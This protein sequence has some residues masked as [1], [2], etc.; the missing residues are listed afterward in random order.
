M[1]ATQ[2]RY[3]AG[4]SA[5]THR[6]KGK[7]HQ[8]N[9]HIRVGLSRVWAAVWSSGLFLVGGGDQRRMVAYVL[10]QARVVEVTR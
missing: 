10:D 7:T 8:R 2:R 1:N 3:T 6:G 5:R 4:R 9:A